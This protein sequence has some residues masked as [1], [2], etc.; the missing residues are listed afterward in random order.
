MIINRRPQASLGFV[1]KMVTVRLFEMYPLLRE[2]KR[3]IKI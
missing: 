1:N 3:G 2:K